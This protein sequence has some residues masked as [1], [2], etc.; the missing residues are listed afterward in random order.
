MLIPIISV[1][2][3]HVVEK[4]ERGAYTPRLD[5][6]FAQENSLFL[7]AYLDLKKYYTSQTGIEMSQEETGLWGF[8]LNTLKDYKTTGI[9]TVNSGLVCIFYVDD[10]DI[11]FSNYHVW[12]EVLEGSK[13]LN[14]DFYSL[15]L[16]SDAGV[17]QAYFSIKAV[18]DFKYFAFD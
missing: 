17:R 14:K 11:V 2:P 9:K 16:K 3:L 7:D 8:Q 18:Q 10:K 5:K 13:N 6:S 4:I 1:Q 15:F 12:E